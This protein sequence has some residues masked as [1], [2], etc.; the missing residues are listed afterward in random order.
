VLFTTRELDRREVNE[1]IRAAHLSA[2]HNVARVVRVDE[3]P[4]LGTGKTDYR[5]LRQRIE[6]AQPARVG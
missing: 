4:V 1:H 6:S 5:A 3:I 2:L